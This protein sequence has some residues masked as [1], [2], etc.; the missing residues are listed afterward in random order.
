MIRAR[1]QS[2]TP[3]SIAQVAN[4]CLWSTSRQWSSPAATRAGVHSRDR[5]RSAV[6]VAAPRR[7][8]N[9]SGRRPAADADD[10]QDPIARVELLGGREDLLPGLEQVETGHGCDS[11]ALEREAATRSNTVATGGR[12]S[13]KAG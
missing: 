7:P 12:A 8:N 13:S 10:R 3:P 6:D 1:Y 4:V 2:C 5:K 9:S 11:R